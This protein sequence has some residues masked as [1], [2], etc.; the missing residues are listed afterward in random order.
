MSDPC[1]QFQLR[2]FP[3]W[4]QQR[5][6]VY[7]GLGHSFWGTWKSIILRN[8]SFR[9]QISYKSLQAW[10]LTPLSPQVARELPISRDTRSE[11]AAVVQVLPATGPRWLALP[12]PQRSAKD[13]QNQHPLRSP[14]PRRSQVQMPKLIWGIWGHIYLYIHIYIM[15]KR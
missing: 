12:R 4:V 7:L 8:T 5:F 9:R 11:E 13:L 1:Y 3:G 6:R 15:P 14:L 10:I 2:P